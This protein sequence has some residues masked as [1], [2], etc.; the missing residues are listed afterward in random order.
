VIAFFSRFLAD[1]DGATAIEYALIAGGIAV[2]II[3]AVA[4]LGTAVKSDF[5]SVEAAF[6]STP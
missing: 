2:A 3:G 4:L 1:D 6:H 5:D